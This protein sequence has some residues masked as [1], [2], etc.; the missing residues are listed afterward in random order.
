MQSIRALNPND[1]KK[2]AKKLNWGIAK[3]RRR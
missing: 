1:N 3:R 2:I